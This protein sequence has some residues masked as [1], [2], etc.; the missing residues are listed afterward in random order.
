MILKILLPDGEVCLL[1]PQLNKLHFFLGLCSHPLEMEDTC[2]QM[3]ESP[4]SNVSLDENV[5]MHDLAKEE[6]NT[7]IDLNVKEM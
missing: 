7:S 2:D 4:I 5:L 3:L 6:M 1:L